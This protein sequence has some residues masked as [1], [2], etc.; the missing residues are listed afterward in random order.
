MDS[1]EIF[2][3]VALP[4]LAISCFVIGVIYRFSLWFRAHFAA[5]AFTIFPG[6]ESRGKLAFEIAKEVT[7]FSRI[8]KVEKKLWIG[9][10]LLHFGLLMALIGH[11]CLVLEWTLL[12]DVLSLDSETR[13]NIAQISGALAG[14]VILSALIYLLSRRFKG[15]M[16]Q[17]SNVEDYFALALL[18]VI[19]LTGLAIRF[20][21]HVELELFREYLGDLLLFRM[22][23]E[24][25][26]LSFYFLIHF[27]T[28]MLLIAVL[29][30]TKLFHLG[31]IFVT[32]RLTNVRL[33]E[34]QS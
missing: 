31:G 28:V 18:L 24:A 7:T 3:L 32:L 8:F 17:T 25:P 15:P 29:P 21:E 6:V 10:W 34:G 22:P 4:Y 14:I 16:F 26:E 19:G 20:V 13:D 12:W 9:A 33:P 11:T 30:F 2:V 1:V 27:L 23:T 5:N